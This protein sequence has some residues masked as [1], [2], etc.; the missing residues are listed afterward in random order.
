MLDDNLAI[1]F[2]ASEIIS[3]TSQF[4]T[5]LSCSSI[6]CTSDVHTLSSLLD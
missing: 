6:G 4:A 3:D 5:V 2:I 1:L